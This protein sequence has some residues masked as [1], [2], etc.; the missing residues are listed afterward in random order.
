MGHHRCQPPP[1]GVGLPTIKRYSLGLQ[2][3]IQCF[4]CEFYVFELEVAIWVTID[5]SHP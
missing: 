4:L 3:V 1:G 5:V 2:I